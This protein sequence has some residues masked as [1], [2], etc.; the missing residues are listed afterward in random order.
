MI[1]T[2]GIR[3]LGK[4]LQVKSAS[5]PEHVAQVEALVNDKLAEAE[6][7]VSGGDTQVVVILALM[8]LAEALLG[9]QNELA[10]ERRNSNERIA[11]LIQRL[12]RQRI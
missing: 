12:D 8:N 10:E 9:A 2:H 3:V 7:A 5:T 4:D 6:A 11:G 1:S